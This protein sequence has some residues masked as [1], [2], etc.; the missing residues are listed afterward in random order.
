MVW[1]GFG[2]CGNCLC[3]SHVT[4]SSLESDNI[5]LCPCERKWKRQA[6]WQKENKCTASLAGPDKIQEYPISSTVS[7]LLCI[8]L[9]PWAHKETVQIKEQANVQCCNKILNKIVHDFSFGF[10]DKMPWSCDRLRARDAF[11]LKVQCLLKHSEQVD[12]HCTWRNKN[13]T[14]V[15][16]KSKKKYV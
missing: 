7:L 15:P 5:Q 12:W 11:I 6:A 9:L 8:L 14:D 1:K 3:E 4:Q 10:L 13:R 16:Y 2:S